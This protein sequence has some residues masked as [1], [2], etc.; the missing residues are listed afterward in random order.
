MAVLNGGLVAGQ[1][2]GLLMVTHAER[3]TPGENSERASLVF[4]VSVDE[5]VAN[6]STQAHRGRRTRR[7]RIATDN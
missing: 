1:A 6:L 3:R 7:W 2:I 5:V 4:T